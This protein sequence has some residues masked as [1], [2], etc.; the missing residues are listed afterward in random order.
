M[1]NVR[2]G[3]FQDLFRAKL[4]SRSPEMGR[5]AKAK[6]VVAIVDTSASQTGIIRTDAIE[7]LRAHG[8]WV[9]RGCKDCDFRL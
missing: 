6:H 9:I 2:I 1:G 4:E 8:G 3:F 5:E 7:V